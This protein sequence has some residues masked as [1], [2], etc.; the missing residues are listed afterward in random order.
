MRNANAQQ[1]Q[2]DIE[3]YRWMVGPESITQLAHP[4][5]EMALVEGEIVQVDEA[6]RMLVDKVKIGRAS[7]RERV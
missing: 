4:E 1:V 6:L 7:C 3:D 5:K 2:T